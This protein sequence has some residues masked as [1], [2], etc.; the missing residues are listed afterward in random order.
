MADHYFAVTGSGS[1]TG[2]DANNPQTYSLTAHN[3]AQAAASAGDTIYFLPGS[4]G[5][6]PSP[7]SSYDNLNFVSTELGGAVFTSASAT[8]YVTVVNYKQGVSLEGFKF[9]DYGIK[10]NANANLTPNIVRSCQFTAP[11]AG[12]YFN[13]G[14][15]QGVGSYAQN[16]LRD[17]SFNINFD[18]TVASARLFNSIGSWQ[19]ERCSFS[20]RT[21]TGN[22]NLDIL[23]STVKMPALLK[24]NIWKLDNSG[25]TVGTALTLN[26]DSTYS[27]F[28]N[29]GSH[30]AATGTNIE[31]DPQF[32]DPDNGDLR[33][34]PSSPCIGAG[35]AS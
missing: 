32:V 31:A 10:M 21:A 23:G 26:S 22:T 30:N 25:I 14:A 11:T 15:F 24:N 6:A 18:G 12:N 34:R 7:F 16:Y 5:A 17:C 3:N 35:T 33:L 8:N 13:Q 1:G 28:Y 9:I 29:M 27:C 20:I 4:Y 19:F 2:A